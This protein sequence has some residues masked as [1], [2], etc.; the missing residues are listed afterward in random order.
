MTGTIEQLVI[1]AVAD[2]LGRQPDAVRLADDLTDALGADQL[3]VMEIVCEIEERSGL[4]LPT[5]A[6]NAKTVG[7][8]IAAVKSAEQRRARPSE[9]KP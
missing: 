8:L 7:D 5:A 9:G 3:D 1:D 6:E 4:K 2:V